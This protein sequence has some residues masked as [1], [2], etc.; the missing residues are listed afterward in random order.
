M[1][2]KQ[3]FLACGRLIFHNTTTDQMNKMFDTIDV[4]KSGKITME[5]FILI[6]QFQHE[7]SDVRVGL[8]KLS[9]LQRVFA[10]IDKDKSGTVDCQEFTTAMR[11]MGCE[12]TDEQLLMLFK[13]GDE[14]SSNHIDYSEFSKLVHHSSVCKT[15]CHYIISSSIE[16]DIVHANIT[17]CEAAMDP[18]ALKILRYWF[19]ETLSACMDLWFG[20]G[21]E[22]DIYIETNFRNMV[23]DARD[24]K[25]NHWICSHMETLALVILLDQFS[26]NIFRHSPETFSCDQLALA[27]VTRS[28]YYGYHTRVC[29]LQSV[30]FCLVLTH[31]E[32]IH[33]QKLCVEMWESIS[34]S[35][36]SNDPLR[37]FDSIFLKHLQ[38]VERF[39]RFP[40]RN[41]VLGRTSTG[42]EL[43]FLADTSFRF[44]LPMKSDGTGFTNT[45]QFDAATTK[46][47]RS[48]KKNCGSV[49]SKIE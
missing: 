41:E 4:D 35:L 19:P 15:L 32:C 44:D 34:A 8:E 3:E 6:K 13:S 2:S 24:G 30:F 9:N 16:L 25:Y 21:N 31:S 12:E 38:V 10:A 27:V 33:H 23:C 17:E 48:S 7:R 45:S 22:I 43:D 1:I 47:V 28:M 29:K 5:E 37:K 20:K 11:I 14:D 46:A 39:D 36:P 18:Q 40:H 26:R 49:E 42:A